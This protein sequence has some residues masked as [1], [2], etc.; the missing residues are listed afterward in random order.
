M[1]AGPPEYETGV[2]PSPR[3][4]VI[5]EIRG[6]NPLAEAPGYSEGQAVVPPSITAM[7]RPPVCET[8]QAA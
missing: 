6:N 4:N 1:A 2:A 8:H 5:E 3:K 7:T